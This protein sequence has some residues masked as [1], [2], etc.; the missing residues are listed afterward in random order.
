MINN[1]YISVLENSPKAKI[2]LHMGRNPGSFYDHQYKIQMSQWESTLAPER[3]A[4]YAKRYDEFWTANY[5]GAQGLINAGIPEKK[6]YVVEHGIDSSIWTPAKRGTRNKIRFLHIDSD[7]PRKRSDLALKAFKNA[8]GDNPDYEL[9][10]KY[11]LVNAHHQVTYNAHN[12][13]DWSRPDVLEHGGDW[14]KNVRAIKSLINIDDLVKLYHF[15]D[16]LI[17]PSEGEGF[18]LIPLQA[19]VTGMPVISTGRW[20]SYEKYLQN[21]II[22][23]K[24][25]PST[26]IK[27]FSGDCVIPD[28]DSTTDLLK[29]VADNISSQSNLFYSQVPDI[30]QEYSWQNKVEPAILELYQR[31]PKKF[32]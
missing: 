3:W 26:Y 22:D 27:R 20:P 28:L 2:Q 4:R 5:W 8:F 14:Y 18:G 17:Y 15:H 7:N 10:L 16:V 32:I 21:N 6:V 19:I 29:Q 25:G 13:L 9:T 12:D 11:S 24:L 31:I 23:S 1:E 30:Q